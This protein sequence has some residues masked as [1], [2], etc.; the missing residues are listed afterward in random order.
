M[1]GGAQD[2]HLPLFDWN[3]TTPASVCSAMVIFRPREGE[4]AALVAGSERALE[5]IRASGIVGG[6][7][8][9]EQ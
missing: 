5:K 8:G 9:E 3:T 6:N 4:V 1:E 7:M 2:L